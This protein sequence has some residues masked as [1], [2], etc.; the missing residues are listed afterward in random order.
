[1]QYFVSDSKFSYS[2]LDLFDQCAY[3]YKLKYIDEHH[4]DKSAWRWNLVL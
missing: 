4:S 2:R 1:M 3:R